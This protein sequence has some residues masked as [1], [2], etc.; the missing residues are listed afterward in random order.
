[1]VWDLSVLVKSTDPERIKEEL[2]EMVADH[3]RFAE[4]HRGKVEGYDAEQL[5][6]MLRAK[7]EMFLR[8][9][10]AM[11]Y[12][13]LAFSADQSDPTASS[14]NDASSRAATEA[15]QLTAFLPVE[16]GRLLAARPELVSHPALNDHRHYLER[17][18]RIAPIS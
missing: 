7:D 3:A 14:L 13:S 1:M 10:G 15:D 11:T 18:Q 16:M 9:E 17:Y 5:A 12:C 2:G 6:G 4:A 8:H